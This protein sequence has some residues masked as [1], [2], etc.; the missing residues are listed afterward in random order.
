[1][2]Y[3]TFKKLEEI[4]WHLLTK[5]E[6]FKQLDSSLE[7][8]TSKQVSLRIS[9]F[10]KNVIQTV[11]KLSIFSIFTRQFLN[12]LVCILF[13]AVLLKISVGEYL[14][15]SVLFFTIL[16]MVLIG[17]FQEMRAENALESLKKF[18]SLKV[19]VI[20]DATLEVI[21]SEFIVPGDVIFLES[22]D[23]IPADC[24]I[25]E[26]SYFKVN[27]SSLTGESLI[28]EKH[29]LDMDKDTV[30]AERKNM[31]YTST[32]VA[33]GKAT[34]ICVA[35]GINTELGKVA[36]LIQEIKPEKTPLQKSIHS[37]TMW[38]A[39]FVLCMILILVFVTYYKGFSWIDILLFAISGSIAAIPEGLPAAVT[40]VLAKGMHIMAKKNA[41]IRRLAAVE[42]LGS[43]TV[44][45]SDKTGT[46]T[47]NQMTVTDVY[48]H[49][50]SKH[51]LGLLYE[52]GVLASNSEIK[53][54]DGV[55]EA[56]GDPTESALLIAA[57]KEG[58]DHIQIRNSYHRLQ[59]IPFESEKR[60]M[61]TVCQGPNG[62]FAFVKG[63]LETLLGFS[64]L[65]KEEKIEI[66]N[67]A[68]KYA[69]K[70]LRIL[71]AGFF[72]LD[73]HKHFDEKSIQGK[74]NIVGFFG[75]LDPPREEAKHAIHCCH[76]AGIR[77]I[78]ITG[79]NP[80]T[81]QVIANKLGIDA[82]KGVLTSYEIQNF[83]DEEMQKRV[84]DI[85]VYARIEPIHK[86]KIVKALKEIGAVVAM[87]G[88]GV[89]D[90]P[91]LE[92]ADIGV[93]MGITGTDVA[94][95]AADMILLDDN[96]SSIQ[97]AVEEGRAIFNRLRFVTTFLLTTCIGEL[98]GLILSVLF[99]D[100]IYLVPLQILWINLVTGVI[101]AI[102]LALEPKTG[103][104]LLQPPRSKEV[105]LVYPGMIQRIL[106]LSFTL[107]LAT[108]GM[109][110][111]VLPH[112]GINIARTMVFTS[113]VVFEWLMAFNV[114]SDEKTVFELG[115]FTNKALLIP[116]VIGA[117]L[118]I[119]I[120]YIPFLQKAFETTP[121][122]AYQIAIVVIPGIL[123]FVLETLRKIFFKNIFNHGKWKKG[124]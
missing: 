60:Y 119:M 44:I 13:L 122:N 105:K 76:K 95:E 85:N 113:L 104:E 63:S 20:R 107:G 80:F 117:I 10:G 84:H 70:G 54:I 83:S 90:A 110:D 40:I 47:L 94:K 27:E 6:L 100:Y 118:Q 43:T 69:A 109:Y 41:L 103:E 50:T 24:R 75:M 8:L 42:T 14:D 98:L 112:Y 72:E 114:R 106:F 96:F 73:T 26:C 74:L 116:V 102:P 19:K 93:S 86:Y 87:T 21:N 15:G 1:M 123:L 49:N 111:L 30:L 38:M 37:L 12:P 18:Y 7:G 2:S 59:E 88:D 92:A 56:I 55:Y 89:N 28:I 58:M 4:K 52:I 78:M 82:S 53:K 101:V 17:F 79:D 97:A 62:L 3:Q 51:T 48:I 36:S 9:A 61:A 33:T 67:E 11:K 64:S 34:V 5:E 108:F 39:L 25:L 99:T 29:A 32:T 23:K 35:S 45:A 31:V 68:K 16:V 121:L 91:A 81:A 46:L 120:L 71:A 77:V 65:S 66:E 22:G 115:L 57:E 124:K